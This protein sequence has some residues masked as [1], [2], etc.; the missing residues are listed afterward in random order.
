MRLIRRFE[1]RVAEQV[2]ANEIAGVCHE[3]I[4]QEAVATGVCAALRDDDVITSTHRGHGHIIAKGGKVRYMLAELFGRTTGYN[5]GRGGSMHIAD[6]RIGIFG[7]NGIVGAGA[8]MACGAAYRFKRAGDDR[9]AVPF[10]GDGA[11]NQGVL[12][13]ALNLGAI[14]N[15]PVVYVCENN[16]YAITTPL[17]EVTKLPPHER[18]R[19]YGM[20]GIVADGMDVQ[21]VYEATR[22]AVRRAR[23]GEGP[24]FLEFETY[25]YVGHYTAE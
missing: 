5:Q 1:E 24:S 8:P 6:M 15:L 14:W 4:G 7:A 20:P 25:R 16:M 21:A 22:E 18:A 19:A 23:A 17:R 9:V 12:H 11:I 13:E 10:F 3:Y 2:D